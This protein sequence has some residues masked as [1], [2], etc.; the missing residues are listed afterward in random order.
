MP[1]FEI[2]KPITTTLTVECASEE[3]AINWANKIVATIEDE[4]GNNM[5]SEEI[6]SFESDVKVSEIKVEHLQSKR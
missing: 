5:Q 6:V 3:E 1:V 2:T 4:N